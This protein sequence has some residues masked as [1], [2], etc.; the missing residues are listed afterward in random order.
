MFRRFSVTF[1]IFSMLLDGVLAGLVLR[2]AGA[3][4]PLLN[5]LPGVADVPFPIELPAE[6]LEYI[7]PVTWIG[8]LLIFSVYDGRKNLHIVDEYSNLTFSSLLA[9]IAMAGVL[10]L[11]YREVSR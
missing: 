3:V 11:T 10:Y 7:L 9:M 5:S 2:I 6:Q 8:I 1:A 4:R